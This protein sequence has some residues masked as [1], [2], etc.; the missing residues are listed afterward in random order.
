MRG[1]LESRFSLSTGQCISFDA[2]QA[3]FVVSCITVVVS[4]LLFYFIYIYSVSWYHLCCA[5]S[6]D[7]R[8]F[9]WCQ[10]VTISP[11]WSLRPTCRLELPRRLCRVSRLHH[12][13]PWRSPLPRN[14]HAASVQLGCVSE[15]GRGWRPY[16]TQSMPEYVCCPSE[17]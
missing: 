12:P 4:L 17:W 11:L 13:M 8:R 7:S 5:G 10:V 1:S 2:R 9:D 14:R 15:R 3:S 6:R 16:Q